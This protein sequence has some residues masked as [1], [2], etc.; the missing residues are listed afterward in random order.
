[1]QSELCREVETFRSIPKTQASSFWWQR[2]RGCAHRSVCF[3][4]PGAS[5]ISASRHGSVSGTSLSSSTFPEPRVAERGIW[6]QHARDRLAVCLSLFV[7]SCWGCSH[8][9]KLPWVICPGSFSH[10][11]PVIKC[12]CTGS[13][14]I[15]AAR[16]GTG[17]VWIY[18]WTLCTSKISIYRSQHHMPPQNLFCK[19]PVP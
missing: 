3:S 1:M 12:E 4:L 13:V 19:G 14:L 17:V 8:T 6:P 18:L 10:G 16:A 15:C 9:T 11:L 5:P 2:L 7:C